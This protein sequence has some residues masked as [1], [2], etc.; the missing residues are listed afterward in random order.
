[1]VKMKEVVSVSNGS[2]ALRCEPW[3]GIW[4]LLVLLTLQ[5]IKLYI[6][7]CIHSVRSLAIFVGLKK[8]EIGA[9]AMKS[10]KMSQSA[11]EYMYRKTVRWKGASLDPLHLA[12]IFTTTE[13]SEEPRGE[14]V[15]DSHLPGTVVRKRSTCT[16]MVNEMSRSSR[17][18]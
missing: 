18:N 14:D 16:Q 9:S 4:P 3:L 6:P 1:M 7:A 12:S 5:G 13:W 2:S 11:S 15:V 10:L 8:E 17:S